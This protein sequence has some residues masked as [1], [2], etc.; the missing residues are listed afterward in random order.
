MKTNRAAHWIVRI[1]GAFLGLAVVGMVGI[2][3]TFGEFAAALSAQATAFQTGCNQAPNISLG[4]LLNA[5][6]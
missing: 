4:N 5:M 1:K 3:F 2:A 6:H